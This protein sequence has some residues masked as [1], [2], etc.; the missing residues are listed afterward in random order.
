MKVGG[1]C[2]PILRTGGGLALAVMHP[3]EDEGVAN[4][5]V[6]SAGERS[7]LARNGVKT[8]DLLRSVDA[9]EL[10]LTSFFESELTRLGEKIMD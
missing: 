1:D 5:S 6:S 2:D 10:D 4:L 9:L 8:V 3:F 7:L